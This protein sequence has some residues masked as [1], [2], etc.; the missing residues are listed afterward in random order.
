MYGALIGGL[1]MGVAQ[2]ISTAFILPTYK[3]AVAFIIMI[4][5]LLIRTQG[6]F[7]GRS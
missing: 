1:L 5:I 7:G 3:P 4:L 6:I 2:Q